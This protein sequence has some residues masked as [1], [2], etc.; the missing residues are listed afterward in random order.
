RERQNSNLKIENIKIL[1]KREEYLQLK[2]TFKDFSKNN[3]M[4]FTD[5]L[6]RITR[7][8]R[9]V[10]VKFENWLD[11]SVAINKIVR[12]FEIE[13]KI[14]LKNIDIFLDE[15]FYYIKPLI[16]RTKRRLKLKNS[17]LKD[18]KKLYPSIFNFLKRN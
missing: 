9:D 1:E 3:L 18:V 6:F 15:I 5:Y 17:I 16:F 2:K 8:E 10:F 14:D 11:I 13:N 12:T 4:F 7:D